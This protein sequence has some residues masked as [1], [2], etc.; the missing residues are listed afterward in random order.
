MRLRNT[1]DFEEERM[2]QDDIVRMAQEAGI[3]ITE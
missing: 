1:R 2:T 3:I